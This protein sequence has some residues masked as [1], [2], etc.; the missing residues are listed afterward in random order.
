MTAVAG[1][2]AAAIEA[3]VASLNAGLDE[4]EAAAKAADP[5]P[6]EVGE[7]GG[8]DAMVWIREK[9]SPGIDNVG[10]TYRQSVFTAQV[11]NKTRFR[12]NAR[13]IA[14]QDPARTLRDVAAKRELIAA[15]LA[16]R[17]DWNAGDEYYSCSQAVDY[18]DPAAEPGSACSD[19][20][21]RGQPCDCGRDARVERLLRILAGIYE[22]GPG[23]H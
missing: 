12:Q 10:L 2:R 5:G 14:R 9:D 23:E 8:Q 18:T 16:E 17:H 22:D 1:S 21:R 11:S 13:H 7:R 15:A 19:P 4:D 20:D 3:L 6:W